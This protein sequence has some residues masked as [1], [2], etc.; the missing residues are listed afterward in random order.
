MHYN[1]L[2]T[3]MDAYV[4]AGGCMRTCIQGKC[5]MA[6]IWRRVALKFISRATNSNFAISIK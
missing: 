6:R 2:L 4:Y 1:D 3:N 5:N